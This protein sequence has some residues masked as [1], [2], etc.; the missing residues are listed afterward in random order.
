[1]FRTWTFCFYNGEIQY[2]KKLYL[3]YGKIIGMLCILSIKCVNCWRFRCVA[4]NGLLSLKYT[5]KTLSVVRSLVNSWTNS[6]FSCSFSLEIQRLIAINVTSSY[7]NY[8]FTTLSLHVT[9]RSV[10]KTMHILTAL[11]LYLNVSARI[12]CLNISCLRRGAC[13]YGS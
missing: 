4:F 11:F 5:L 7:T 6:T 9:T 13:I 2:P 12:S 1:M 10:R 3:V 8:T